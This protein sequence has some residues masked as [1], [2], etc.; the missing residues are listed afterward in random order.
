MDS[1]RC[2]DPTELAGFLAGRTPRS[3]S[4]W[5]AEHLKLCS[6]CESALQELDREGDPLLTALTG[7]A[8]LHGQATEPIPPHL[9]ALAKSARQDR[10]TKLGRFE[11]LGE[12]GSGSYGTVFKARDAKLGR[13]VAIKMLRANRLAGPEEL[14]RFLREARSFA[15]V[16]HPGI[17]TLYEIGQD[18]GQYY[19]VE[20]Y[21]EGVTLADRMAQGPLPFRDSAD[22]LARVCEAL[23][24][25]HQKGVIHRDLKP[26]NILLDREG[27]PH[28]TDFGIA[29]VEGEEKP[30]TQDGQ[31]LGTPAY[32]SP[33]QAR[34]ESH[35]VDA[36]SDVY[37]FGVI[38]YELLT[39]ERPFQ[40]N[41]RMLLLQV[42]EDEPRPP[43]QLNDKIP[44]DLETICLKAMSKSPD[45]RYATALE[46]AEDLRRH[47]AGEPI[48]A[49]P[50]TGLERALSWT[51]R[52]PAA[53]ALVT[54]S[55]AA[56]LMLAAT[57]SVSY[58]RIAR[59]QSHTKEALGRET[60]AKDDLFKAL[61]QNA[62]LTSDALKEFNEYYS[63]EVVSRLTDKTIQVTHDYTA[64]KNAIPL[65]ATMSVELADRISKKGSGIG[66][67]I[68]L[69]SDH[70]F[71][72]RQA[73]GGP[74]DEFQQEALRQLRSDPAA[75]FYRLEDLKGRRSLRYATASRMEKRCVDCHNSMK[76]SPKRDWKEGDVV[77]VYEVSFPVDALDPRPR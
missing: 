66:M 56:T 39:Q 9:L 52:R 40:G 26:A 1:A 65:P 15:Q 69:F 3:R 71:P 67:Q 77:G 60:R 18:E 13:T 74:K 48:L 11:F 10:P 30:V 2:P 31:V 22:L 16:S 34:G 49:R 12:I 57:F 45:P 23:H 8:S 41:R 70:P 4:D 35:K 44:R 54:V 6:R 24:V 42:L 46:L 21:V 73:E 29:K 38:L 7:S 55:I 17:V 51:R 14:E 25:A 68:R 43:R 64:R 19:L 58:V 63:S 75:P 61:V 72:W 5:I 36:R 76:E 37:S 32:M 47:L 59:E 27:H 50:Q 53:A 20:E 62:R 33:E 28:L